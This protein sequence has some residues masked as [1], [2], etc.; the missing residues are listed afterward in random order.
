MPAARPSRGSSLQLEDPRTP[1]SVTSGDF[2]V[3][4]E[5]PGAHGYHHLSWDI[6]V[7]ASSFLNLE[8]P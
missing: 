8:S 6:L 4:V 3:T 7:F 1:R 2:W 5:S